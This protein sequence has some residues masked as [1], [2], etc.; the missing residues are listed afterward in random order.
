MPR[1]T[2]PHKTTTPGDAKAAAL[3]AALDAARKRLLL[4]TLETRGSDRLDF[5]DLS[6]GLVREALAAMFDAGCAAAHAAPAQPTEPDEVLATL[7]ITRTDGRKTGGTWVTGTIAGHTFEA[8][9]FPEHAEVASYELGDS[10]ISKLHLRDAAGKTVV[11]FD[12]GW[13]VE[14]A[15]PAAK[16]I[17]DLLVAGLAET[18]FG[19]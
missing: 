4:E 11:N 8:L 13:D 6:V 3:A 16:V 15:T 19:R 14:P 18:V 5:H 10:R 1:P 9:V 17:T 2:R 12:R 7:K